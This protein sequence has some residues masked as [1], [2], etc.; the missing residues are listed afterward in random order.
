MYK[1]LYILYIPLLLIEWL[2]DLF[3]KIW[4]SVHDSVKDITLALEKLI[5]EPVI[6]KPTEKS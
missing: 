3:S 6:Q 4:T 1:L 2:V 5:N